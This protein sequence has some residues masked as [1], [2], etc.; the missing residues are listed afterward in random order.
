[1]GIS[2]GTSPGE[3]AGAA[4]TVPAQGLPS[5]G[6]LVASVVSGGDSADIQPVCTGTVQPVTKTL[7]Y[8]LVSSIRVTAISS[9][10][11]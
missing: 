2:D 6:S 8:Q 1:M 5:H 3:R 4:L 9:K 10:N 11:D 7:L